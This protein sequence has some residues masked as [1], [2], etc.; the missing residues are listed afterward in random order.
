MFGMEMESFKEFKYIFGYGVDLYIDWI[1]NR[2]EFFIEEFMFGV[3]V[4]E[5]QY[6]VDFGKLIIEINRII[7]NISDVKGCFE[8]EEVMERVR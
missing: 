4:E 8:R 3:R 7:S 6:N 2:W 5:E 1:V